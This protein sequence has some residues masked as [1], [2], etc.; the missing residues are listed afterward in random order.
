VRP[1]A[2]PKRRGPLEFD[3]A[4]DQINRAKHG[5]SLAEAARL[6]FGTAQI[7]PDDRRDYGEPRFRALGLIDGEVYFLAF[8]VRDGR[9]RPISL[10]KANRREIE[11]YAGRH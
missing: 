3:D 7:R 2:Y 10:R 8:T 11:R 9:L 1:P 6:A 5:V 4:K